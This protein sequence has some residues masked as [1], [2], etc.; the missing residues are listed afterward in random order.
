MNQAGTSRSQPA[1]IGRRVLPAKISVTLP[2][3]RASS[4]MISAGTMNRATPSPS[5]PICSVC[6]IGLT[7]SI[8]FCGT[9]ASTLLVPKMNMIAIT[10]AAMSTD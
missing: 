3:C 6:G 7:R 10:G 4:M 1:T 9:S 8:W 2:I 5:N